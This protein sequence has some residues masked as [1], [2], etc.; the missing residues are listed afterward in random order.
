LSENFQPILDPD[1]NDANSL[2]SEWTYSSDPRVS[3]QIQDSELNI[4]FK[5]EETG[6]A[7]GNVTF[8]IFKEFEFPYSGSPE[9]FR[10]FIKFLVSGSTTL[11]V[12]TEQ[13][14]NKTDPDNWKIETRTVNASYYDAPVNFRIFLERVG[15][16]RYLIWPLARYGGYQ[17]DGME[18]NGTFTKD[19]GELI[20]SEDGIPMDSQGPTAVFSY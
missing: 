17:P 9:S 13:Y 6:S 8:E 11:R 14:V 2:A 19:T 10:G 5:R 3:A 15:G 12:L 16:K 7:Y 1:F 20:N 18:Q 4:E